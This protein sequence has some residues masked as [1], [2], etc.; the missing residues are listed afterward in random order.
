MNNRIIVLFNE[1][2]LNVFDQEVDFQDI[3][4]DKCRF[5]SYVGYYKEFK[6]DVLVVNVIHPDL[7]FVRS[8]DPCKEIVYPDCIAEYPYLFKGEK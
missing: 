4:T 2:T 8:G 5:P 6:R 3:F 7:P 1:E